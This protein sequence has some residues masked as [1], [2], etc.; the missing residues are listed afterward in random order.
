[1]AKLIFYSHLTKTQ[2]HDIINVYNYHFING[3]IMKKVLNLIVLLVF[4]I[5]ATLTV[6]PMTAYA[7]PQTGADIVFAY[8]MQN[9]GGAD[10][11]TINKDG[12]IKWSS[13]DQAVIFNIR[14]G[15]SLI[16]MLQSPGQYYIKFWYKN[17]S[18]TKDDVQGIWGNNTNEDKNPPGPCDDPEKLIKYDGLTS[19]VVNRH[20]AGQWNCAVIPITTVLTPTPTDL[21]VEQT[22]R[23]QVINSAGL[24][25]TGQYLYYSSSPDPLTPVYAD[26]PEFENPVAPVNE[27]ITWPDDAL[28]PR[29][30]EPADVIDAVDIDGANAP[31]QLLARVS[32][33]IINKHKPRVSLVSRIEGNTSEAFNKQWDTV[34]GLEL[35]DIPQLS[36][37]DRIIKGIV[38]KYRAEFSGYVLYPANSA[39]A[40]AAATEA[41]LY[42]AIPITPDMVT[43]VEGLGLT[44]VGTDFTD[45]TAFPPTSYPCENNGTNEVGHRN[46]AQWIY[47][48]LRNA[49]GERPGY[50]K[51]II[52]FTD[53][54]MRRQ[55]S[56]CIDLAAATGSPIVFAD[57][58]VAA[59]RPILQSFYND[60]NSAFPMTDTH[61]G[62]LGIGFWFNEGYGVK[63]TS[64][65]GISVVP[66]DNFR[67]YTIWASAT[68]NVVDPPT[69]SAKPIYSPDKKYIALQVSDGDN[70]S[71]FSG[72]QILGDFWGSPNRGRAPITYTAPPA[73]IDAAP[74]MFN[75]YY[76]T[77]KPNDAFTCGPTGLGYYQTGI[78]T[79]TWEMS[80]F[81]K[82]GETDRD[83]FGRKSAAGTDFPTY[84]AKWTNEYFEKT[85]INSTT[86]WYSIGGAN[87][88]NN[89]N[90]F[91]SFANFPSLLGIFS[92]TGH[93]DVGVTSGATYW[94]NDE[95]PQKVFDPGV[96][97]QGRYQD[98]FSGMSNTLKAIP[99]AAR[100]ENEEQFYTYQMVAWSGA[101][102]GG[103]DV[104][105]KTAYGER[106]E[107]M[108]R[109][110]LDN[111]GT[112]KEFVRGD[113]FLMLMQEAKGNPINNALR[114]TTRTYN[115]T[116]GAKLVDG[117]FGET[118]SWTSNGTEE[119]RWVTIDFTRRVN[120]SRYVIKNAELTGL[121]ANLNTKAY[122]V[123]VSNDN[124]TWTLAGGKTNNTAATDYGTF[125][126]PDTGEENRYRFVRFTITDAGADD[127][128]RLGEIEIF[129]VNNQ[130]KV[131]YDN[132]QQAMDAFDD[133]DFYKYTPASWAKAAE[134]NAK[135]VT[136]YEKANPTQKN[137]DDAADKLNDSLAVLVPIEKMDTDFNGTIEVNDAFVALQS[138]TDSI[139]LHAEHVKYAADLDDNGIVTAAEALDILKHVLGL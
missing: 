91:A 120:L 125:T 139:T 73:L 121:P 15:P 51:R 78:A 135:A 28:M 22:L 48:N 11:R 115:N 35:E 55:G 106:M 118:H 25:T 33:G 100:E 2:A 43:T 16:K 116:N 97:G 105:G 83:L 64:L 37:R 67:N 126:I 132:I 70:I 74:A 46:S 75:Y 62:P 20:T 131:Y 137:L 109:F 88:M 112:Y 49:N 123:E 24:I 133:C 86:L 102:N 47:N 113:H 104:D 40:G 53:P 63:G 58:G 26:T 13:S 130:T 93:D 31:E 87:A 14:I 9:S 99:N 84:Y 38:S 10:R 29:M 108:V 94:S 81:E 128:I 52:C 39:I 30:A 66:S 79:N 117:S 5:S 18:Y 61:V 60:M 122:K 72:A 85:G 138:A 12:S 3:I 8:N 41:S 50:N 111:R 77:A 92:M 1:M 6:I 103:A 76:S 36:V 32:Q 71:M 129:G 114:A 4:T 42:E 95:I 80:E 96:G 89:L 54:T 90:K 127:I 134:L 136:E 119:D 45:T 57:Y 34:A 101:K 7:A 98:H 23:A 110:A 82:I 65:Y 21:G 59:S 56:Q 124:K 17:G 69:V 44:R 19:A 27:G 68:D 107:N